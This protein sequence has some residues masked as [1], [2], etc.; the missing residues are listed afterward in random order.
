MNLRLIFATLFAS[1]LFITACSKSKDDSSQDD[2][3]EEGTRIDGDILV[4]TKNANENA[5]PGIKKAAPAQIARSL[6]YHGEI[7]GLP[8]KFAAIVARL[9]GIVTKVNF[10]EGDKV[11]QGEAMV[12]IESKKLAESKLAY[13]ESEHRLDFA[14]QALEREASM[15]E[16][17]IS[18]K[19]AY[20]KVAHEK[21]E[22]I[23]NH[24]SA[25][26]QLKLLGF[27]EQWLHKLEKN[28]NQKMTS[29]TLKA[30]FTGEVLSTEVTMGE[31]VMEDKTLFTVA[32]L[33]ELQVEIKVP[34]TAVSVFKKEMKVVVIS[35][36]LNLTSD[37][38]VK[39]ISSVANKETRTVSVKINIPN[40]DGKWRPGT[41]ARVELKNKMVE[42]KTA[43]PLGCVHEFDDGL[44]VFVK[45]D[46]LSYKRVPVTVGVKDDKYIEI[47]SGLKTGDPVVVDNSLALKSEWIKRSGE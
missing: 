34:L 6:S 22:A 11:E 14:A 25:L 27:S 28:P 44:F 4:L 12:T 5:K 16:K 43:I 9:E 31:A 21:E 35:D 3:T 26:Q 19:E 15:V 24:A 29:Y 32:D 18:T 42:A 20:Q 23:L 2:K 1:S 17:K 36:E 45:S 40:P 13:L 37:G 47:T 7:G 30:P 41:N 33:S 46:T 39:F 8:E 10:K 38:V